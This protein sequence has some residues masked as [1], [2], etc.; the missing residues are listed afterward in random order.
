MELTLCWEHHEDLRKLNFKINNSMNDG[1]A[2][3]QSCKRTGTGKKF[4]MLQYFI[5]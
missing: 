5:I 2:C 3:C 4:N 1:H